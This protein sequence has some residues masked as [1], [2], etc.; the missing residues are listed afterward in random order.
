MRRRTWLF[1]LGC[2]LHAAP[3]GFGQTADA[4]SLKKEG[5]A[6]FR[7][8]H[9]ARAETLLGHALDSA[10]RQNDNQEIADIWS[11]LGDIYSNEERFS[12]AEHA[13]QKALSILRQS[14][15]SPTEVVTALRNLGIAYS[16]QWRNQEAINTLKQAWN[17][18]RI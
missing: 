17:I 12:E 1:L 13:Y 7:A 8:G 11:G 9:L 18:I 6:E 5:I 15:S 3:D 10:N 2:F 14:S 16:L 4:R